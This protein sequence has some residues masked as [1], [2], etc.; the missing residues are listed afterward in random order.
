MKRFFRIVITVIV[1]SLPVS[2]V[3]ARSGSDP[4]LRPQLGVWFGPVTPVYTQWNEVDTAIGG[5][6][7]FRYN[8]GSSP[9]K[10]AVDASYQDHSSR[11]V[12]GLTLVPVYGSLMYRIP[13]DFLISF[14]LRAGAGGSY[15]TIRPENKSQWDPMF[16]LG[17]EMSFPAGTLANIGLRIDYLNINERYTTS[18]KRDC[19]MINAGI[20]VNFNIN[21]FK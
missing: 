15:V 6:G 21:L 13:F 17:W 3:Y 2:A 16:I 10:L 8:L 4:F 9:F 20:V 19:H 5:G 18:A 11:G 1:I 14:Q 12:N 7:Y